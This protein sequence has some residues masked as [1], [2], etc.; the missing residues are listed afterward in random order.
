MLPSE[1]IHSFAWPIPGRCKLEAGCRR[2]R[3]TS[4]RYWVLG[5]TRSFS[6]SKIDLAAL[7]P[8]REQ[9]SAGCIFVDYFFEQQVTHNQPLDG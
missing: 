5:G 1:S 3:K 8:K 7:A 4:I 6:L 9:P 2:K